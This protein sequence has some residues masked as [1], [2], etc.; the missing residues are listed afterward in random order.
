MPT[1]TSSGLGSGLE[2]NSIVESLVAAEKDPITNRIEADAAQ[3]TAQISALGQVNSLLSTLQ[4]SYRDLNKNS[5]FNSTGTISSDESIV[6]ATT[7]FGATTGVYEV[8]VQALAQQHTLITHVANTYS[9]VDDVI[10]GGTIAIRF[11]SYSGGNF[12][13]GA[14]STNQSIDIADNA[15]MSDIKE[16]INSGSYGITASILFDGTGY[17]LTLQNDKS[18]AEQA[19]EITITDDDGDH[20]N[21]SG[22]SSLAFDG[23]TNNMEQTLNAQDALIT[24]NGLAIT[25]DS[26]SISQ[27]VEGVTFELN[28]AEIGKKVK[29]TVNSDTSKVEAQIHDFV[30][31]Y[32]QVV[33][34][35]TEFTAFNSSTDK[36]VLIGD[37]SIRSIESF[38]RNI[39]NTRLKNID[40]SVKSMADLGILTTREGTLEINEDT[41]NGVAVFSDV[42]ANNI[43]DVAKFFAKSGSTSS[44]D[45]AYLSSSSST[46]EGQYRVEVTQIATQGKLQG[47]NTLPAD[48][49]VSP[50]VV[51][52]SNNAFVMRIDGIKSNAIQLT[53][54][55]YS[56]ESSLI[57]EIQSQINSDATLKDKGISVNVTIENQQLVISSNS[58][59]S[60]STVAMLNVDDSITSD[61]VIDFSSP[62]FVIS[63]T[64]GFDIDIG[65]SLG[66]IDIQG[67]YAT[68]ADLI[69]ALQDELLAK[70]GEVATVSIADNKLTITSD[71]GNSVGISNLGAT[72]LAEIGLSD[73]SLASNLG[74]GISNGTTGLGAQGTI[75]GSDAFSDGQYLLAQ[76]G[77]GDAQGIKVQVKAGDFIYQSQNTVSSYPLTAS[78]DT[79]FEITVDGITSASIDVSGQ[80]FTSDD[81]LKTAIQNLLNAD[82]N[83]SSAGE[84]VTIDIVNGKVKLTSSTAGSHLQV[85][86]VGSSGELGLT[87]DSAIISSSI[88]FSEGIASKID[89]YLGVIID[90]SISKNDG[91]VYSSNVKGAAASTL[92]DAKTDSLF[93]KLIEVD[94]QEQSLNY[95]MELYEKRL[96]KQFNA[97]DLLVAQLNGASQSLQGT[98]DALPGYT[99]DKK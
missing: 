2:I 25:R 21:S 45:I 92:I 3:A 24:F 98:L 41:T 4:S 88:S 58:Y 48:F 5:T 9:S 57:A 16:A 87:V 34:K 91:D 70:T 23:T 36:G 68:E 86:A 1:I 52:E 29:I 26:N 47:T 51:N 97:M 54:G 99:R 14:N 30:E 44:S 27:I 71:T 49:S 80:T 82:V 69:T 95:K 84:T 46:K 7:G 17:R 50:F 43:G 72:S 13:P 60:S 77:S 19:M 31:S 15:S 18:G 59:G 74:V 64:S 78:A 10:G 6:E 11:G 94:K 96:F 33:A 28:N 85:S 81:E 32:N 22:L 75:N 89:I 40:G 20:T 55:S 79:N 66:S 56:T 63:A 65:G 61:S 53:Q 35:I 8:E 42:L 93:K 62:P 90:N 83:L 38:M 73:T 12:T 39:L 37:S 67:S 76:S